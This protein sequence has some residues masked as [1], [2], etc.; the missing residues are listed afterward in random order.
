MEQHLNWRSKMVNVI[1]AFVLG[2][3]IG[4]FGA[5]IYLATKKPKAVK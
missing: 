3:I 1:V 2:F 4:G 5:Y